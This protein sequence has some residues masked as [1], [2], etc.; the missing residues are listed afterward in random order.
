MRATSASVRPGGA[1]MMRHESEPR[2]TTAPRGRRRHAA[3]PST[4]RLGDALGRLEPGG[5]PKLV[6][7]VRLLPREVAVLAAEVAVRR[8]LLIDRTVE[9]QV[10]AEGAG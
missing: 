3:G 6:G 2:R 8:G 7:L 9:V 10:L 4:E 1:E 5:P